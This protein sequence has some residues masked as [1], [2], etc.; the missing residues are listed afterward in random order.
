MPDLAAADFSGSGVFLEIGNGKISVR[1][2][3]GRGK[4][5]RWQGKKERKEKDKP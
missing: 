2:G 1:Y 3:R 5:F 4:R